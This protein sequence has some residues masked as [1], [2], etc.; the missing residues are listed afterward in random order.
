MQEGSASSYGGTDAASAS[1]RLGWTICCDLT[2]GRSSGGS[3]SGRVSWDLGVDD[4]VQLGVNV[5]TSILKARPAVL[6]GKINLFFF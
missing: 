4:L 5:P 2:G 6:A 3:G 1:E